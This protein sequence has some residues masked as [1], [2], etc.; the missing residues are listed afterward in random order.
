MYNDFFSNIYKKKLMAIIK[1]FQLQKKQILN[2]S[3]SI[4][5]VLLTLPHD[6]IKL[7]SNILVA[8]TVFK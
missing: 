6:V 4:Q 2:I 8:K 1:E 7:L 5:C 3:F